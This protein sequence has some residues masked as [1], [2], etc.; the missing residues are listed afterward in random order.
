MGEEHIFWSLHL[1]S[2]FFVLGRKEE[3]QFQECLENECTYTCSV[4]PVSMLN[5]TAN[6]SGFL[7]SKIN[8]TSRI[9]TFEGLRETLSSGL[10]SS[11]W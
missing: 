4:G 8:C 11:P 6:K 10:Y 5:V 2:I 1:K 3:S 9:N 7:V